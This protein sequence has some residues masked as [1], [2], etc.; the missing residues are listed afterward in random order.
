MIETKTLFSS[1]L[2]EHDGMTVYWFN[3]F[4]SVK[5]SFCHLL[6]PVYFHMKR[7]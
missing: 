7:Y 1:T 3:P 4:Q 6:S 5:F 2:Y